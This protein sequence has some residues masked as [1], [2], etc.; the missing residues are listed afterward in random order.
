MLKINNTLISS[1]RGRSLDSH[2]RTVSTEGLFCLFSWSRLD[3]LSHQEQRRSRLPSSL[4]ADAG[5]EV[6]LLEWGREI[7]GVFVVSR[8]ISETKFVESSSGFFK[9][10]T[11]GWDICIAQDTRP[12]A[13][14]LDTHL[15]TH[16]HTHL[17]KRAH[18][19]AH[20]H[21]T[22]R[23]RHQAGANHLA[24]DAREAARL[25]IG[26]QDEVVQIRATRVVVVWTV[27]VIPLKYI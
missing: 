15:D 21:T 13:T 11:L 10:R 22:R 16:T 7:H 20:T 6:C 17:H 26:N 8:P 24:Q 9:R 4:L 23:R 25:G 18:T 3:Q 5:H 12:G 2:L 19:Y 14:H 27:P 1:V